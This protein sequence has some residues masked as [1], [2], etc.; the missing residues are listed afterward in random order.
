MLDQLAV[1]DIL[2]WP[3]YQFDKAE[4]QKT[5]HRELANLTLHHKQHCPAYG[6]L[7][8]T[9]GK[10]DGTKDL[11][12]LFPLPVQLFKTQNLKSVD[13]SEVVKTMTSSGTTGQNVSHIYLDKDTASLQIKVLSKIMT[14]TIGQK[15]LPMLIID[16]PA[17]VKDRTKFSARTTGILGFSMYGRDLTF[18]LNDDMSVN[19]EAIQAFSEKY[20]DSNVLI[21]GFT[22]IV[23]LHFILALEKDNHSID[24]PNGILIHG[25]GWKKLVDQAVDKETFKAR[26]SAVT[27]VNSVY[28]YYGMVEQTGSIFMECN[29]GH[30]H[31]SSW[32]DILIRSPKDFSVLPYGESGVIQLFSALP[33][34]Y[35]GHS[36]LTEDVG[37]IIGEDDCP[38]GK[39]GVYF[40][41]EGRMQQAEVRGCS[42]TYSN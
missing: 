39:K 8:S 16:C 37:R 17:T 14:E 7:L 42:D 34:S 25:G 12:N 15:R 32:S 20:A 21:F 41:V 26:F 28:N 36:L 13:D 9:F 5:L 30:F 31:C 3:A 24:L 18:A 1:I 19:Y 29:A 38:C 40:Q 27:S 6:K 10:G 33:R 11:E 23:W 2:E 4:K 35:P 22:F